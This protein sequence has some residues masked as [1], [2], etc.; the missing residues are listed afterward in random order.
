M[1]YFRPSVRYLAFDDADFLAAFGGLMGLLAGISV[2]SI[3]EL[4]VAIVKCCRFSADK[5]K[6]SPETVQRIRSQKEYLV[7]KEHLFYY[8]SQ[9][10]VELMRASNIHGVRYLND[11]KV[12]VIERVFWFIIICVLMAFCSILVFNSLNDLQGN[13]VVVAIDEKIWSVEDVRLS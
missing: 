11:K 7:N 9:A 2:F 13:S 8:L 6:I 5:S 12:K 4:L 3:I 1:T 10:L